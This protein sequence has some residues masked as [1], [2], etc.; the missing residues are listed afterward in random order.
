[1]VMHVASKASNNSCP[2]A[3]LGLTLGQPVS[4]T[5]IDLVF[6]LARSEA[7]LDAPERDFA[8][9]PVAEIY[10]YGAMA[11]RDRADTVRISRWPTSPDPRTNSR[12]L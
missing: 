2:E 6:E 5:E 1:M 12:H 7:S 4:D 10:G 11:E 3:E 9:N 8:V